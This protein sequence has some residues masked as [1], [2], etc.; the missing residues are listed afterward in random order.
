MQ[1]ECRKCAGKGKINTST[2]H[3]CAGKLTKQALDELN[4]YI[5][6]GTPDG[7]EE[8][9]Q[10]AADESVDVRAGNVI[11]KVQ[12]LPHKRFKREGDNL[13]INVDITLKQAL[14]GFEIEIP[15]LDGHMVK[16]SRKAG[17]TVQH[18]Q[19]ERVPNEGMPK[20]GMY[21]EFGDLYVVY[22]VKFP[23]KIDDK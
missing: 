8:T 3:T 19:I 13:R 7:Y 18:G 5:E 12:Q 20:Y 17:K 2:C 6:K 14:L 22:Q 16:L 21:S 4:V 9:F 23:K 10:D 15:H 1:V 11:F